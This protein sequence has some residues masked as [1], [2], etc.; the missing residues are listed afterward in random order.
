M[1][2]VAR[3]RVLVATGDVVKARMAGPAI[4]AWQVARALAV[5]HTVHLVSSLECD[6]QSP[7]FAT[8]TVDEA[9]F[10]ELLDWCDIVIFQGHL[11]RAFPKLRTSDKIVVADI[12]DPFHLE[13]LEQA[14]GLAPIDRQALTVQV[15]SVL[16]EQLLR[17]DFM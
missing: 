14:R 6:L 8:S 13:L 4:R 10:D 11:M 3:R 5:D 17:A 1:T 9:A 7:T 12:Y 2:D 16:N 15:N